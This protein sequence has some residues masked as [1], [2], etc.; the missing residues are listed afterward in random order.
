MVSGD[1]IVVRE[2]L[3]RESKE[4]ITDF[5]GKRRLLIVDEAQ[6]IPHI[7]LNLKILVDSTPEV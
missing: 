4:K 7:G 6:Y 2:Y 3:G 1:D 5:V